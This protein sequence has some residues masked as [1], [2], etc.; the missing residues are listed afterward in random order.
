[1]VS[2][3]K[4]QPAMVQPGALRSLEAAP[5]R[6]C[7]AAFAEGAAAAKGFNNRSMEIL[8]GWLRILW[9]CLMGEKRN[10][11]SENTLDMYTS[12]NTLDQICDMCVIC[13]IC[14]LYTDMS[15][16]SANGSSKTA[17]SYTTL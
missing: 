10:H 6:F 2:T 3:S 5:R 15:Y 17:T 9:N 16:Q 14:D 7:F 1:M 8:S 11:K 13:V 12:I 4:F